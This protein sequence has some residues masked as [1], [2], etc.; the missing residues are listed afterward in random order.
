M[1]MSA[2]LVCTEIV[3]VM[4]CAVRCG[5]VRGSKKIVVLNYILLI[6]PIT[7]NCIF[8]DVK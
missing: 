7:I 6:V 8:G 4:V 5:R 2:A 1:P 3:G